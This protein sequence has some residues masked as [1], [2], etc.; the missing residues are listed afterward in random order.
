MGAHHHTSEYRR[1]LRE[2][3]ARG[4]FQ[5]CMTAGSVPGCQVNLDTTVK[6]GRPGHMTLG[7]RIDVDA[8]PQLAYNPRNYGPQCEPCNAAGG[9]QITNAKRR[10]IRRQDLITSPDWT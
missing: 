1:C 2:L 10:G 4:R 5:R 8:A 9:A 6:R 3:K 7:H